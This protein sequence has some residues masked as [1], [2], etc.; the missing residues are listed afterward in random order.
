MFDIFLQSLSP[1]PE[2]K[3]QKSRKYNRDLEEM[4]PGINLW[5]NLGINNLLKISKEI[6]KR[7][8]EEEEEDSWK[9]TK[10]ISKGLSGRTQEKS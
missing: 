6:P 1:P 8:L 7:I 4:Y 9:T 3:S 2:V 5:K 10:I